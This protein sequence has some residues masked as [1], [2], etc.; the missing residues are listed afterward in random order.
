MTRPTGAAA[1][2]G[3]G[4]SLPPSSSSQ[5][6][7]KKTSTTIPSAATTANLEESKGGTTASSAADNPWGLDQ[8]QYYI[9]LG[10]VA[11]F[12]QFRSTL[13]KPISAIQQQEADDDPFGP[14]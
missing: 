1:S 4:P 11:K 3:A 2:K 8:S 10:G 14:Y 7:A 9:E 13:K 12:L 5:V 6:K